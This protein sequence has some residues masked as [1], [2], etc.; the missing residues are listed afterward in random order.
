[1][2]VRVALEMRLILGAE[3][4]SAKVKEMAERG[5]T[6]RI[7]SRVSLSNILFHWATGKGIRVRS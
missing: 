3:L 6:A 7:V 5:A 1:M 4:K 2:E